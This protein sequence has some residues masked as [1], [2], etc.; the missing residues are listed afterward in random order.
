VGLIILYT[1]MFF[2]NIVLY[3]VKPLIIN[4]FGGDSDSL[5][6]VLSELYVFYIAKL[7]LNCISISLFGIIRAIGKD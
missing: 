6:L 5:R 2:S 3:F 7:N 1:L 4:V